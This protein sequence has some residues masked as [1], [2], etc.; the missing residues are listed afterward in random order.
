M[1]RRHSLVIPF[2]E[3]LLDA[4][5]VAELP[6]HSDLADSYLDGLRR[7]IDKLRSEDQQLLDYCYGDDLSVQQIAERIARSRQSVG[8]SLLRIR[9]ELMRCVET[10]LL[11]EEHPVNATIADNDR[12]WQITDTVCSGSPSQEEMD[13]LAGL[14]ANDKEAQQLYLAYCQLHASLG[15]ELR[16][17]RA[18]KA[19]CE[20]TREELFSSD[21]DHIKATNSAPPLSFFSDALHGTVGFFSQ[22]MPFALLI[23][24]VVTGLGLL[25]G[26]LVYVTHHK[27]MADDT[28]QPNAVYCQVGSESN[29]IRYGLRRPRIRH[30]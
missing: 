1:K 8:K 26:S 6:P 16:G 3:E 29:A 7:C 20:R 13:E 25:A 17:R 2:S 9:R 11:Q 30:G 15:Y 23:A 10:R 24:T 21:D 12:F 18:G 22:E 27:Q 28:L 5:A 4:L 19:A 14:L